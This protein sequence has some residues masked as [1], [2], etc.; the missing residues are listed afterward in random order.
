MSSFFTICVITGRTNKGLHKHTHLHL[1]DWHIDYSTTVLNQTIIKW[2][3]NKTYLYNNTPTALKH[4]TVSN[5]SPTST[6]SLRWVF[7]RVHFLSSFFFF[8]LIIRS[9]RLRLK[10]ATCNFQPNALKHQWKCFILLEY[11]FFPPLELAV[12]KDSV[13]WLILSF[14]KNVVLF[15]WSVC[16]STVIFHI[17]SSWNIERILL[18]Y[19]ATWNHTNRSQFMHTCSIKP[20]FILTMYLSSRLAHKSLLI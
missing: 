16:P 8:F 2:D 19:L 9:L 6:S 12:Q 10:G 1:N 11:L 20:S 3:E 14:E 17:F 15:S 13:P 18:T 7:F 5:L 4:S